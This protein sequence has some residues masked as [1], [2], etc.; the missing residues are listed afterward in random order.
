MLRESLNTVT[1]SFTELEA[2]SG[3][4]IRNTVSPPLTLLIGSAP[5]SKMTDN[6]SSF[7]TG[8]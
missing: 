2:E 4:A 6:E 3:Q 1:T 8:H 5:L 7:T